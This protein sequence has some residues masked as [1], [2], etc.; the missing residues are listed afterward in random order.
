MQSHVWTQPLDS[1]LHTLHATQIR[2]QWSLC[3]SAYVPLM[4]DT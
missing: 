2:K 3:W 1:W 4:G